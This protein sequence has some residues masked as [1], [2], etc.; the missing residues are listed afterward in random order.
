M[1]C[2][3]CQK[4]KIKRIIKEADKALERYYN[5]LRRKNDTSKQNKGKHLRERSQG[6]I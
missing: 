3:E 1:V 6:C 4:R 5:K 2:E